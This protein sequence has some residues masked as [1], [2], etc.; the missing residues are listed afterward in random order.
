MMRLYCVELFYVFL[1]RFCSEGSKGVAT[2]G[3]PPAG[4]ATH[5]QAIC[6]SSRLWPGPP[7]RATTRGQAATGAARKG[8]APTKALPTGTAPASLPRGAAQG[9]SVAH[10]ATS[11]SATACAGV[12][13]TIVRGQMA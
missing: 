13:T 11:D 4:V 7:T 8:V 10:G 6:R 2:Y 12:A 5:G 9:Q 1:L 3:Q